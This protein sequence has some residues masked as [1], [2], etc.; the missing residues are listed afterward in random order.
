MRP[1]LDNCTP[2]IVSYFVGDADD[3]ELDTSCGY[4]C[5]KTNDGCC[6]TPKGLGAALSFFT[7]EYGTNHEC[8]YMIKITPTDII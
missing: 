4:M 8:M 2:Y 1:F 3:E 7:F 6:N 5:C